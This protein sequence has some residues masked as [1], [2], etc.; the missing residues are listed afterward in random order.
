MAH[1]DKN[2]F[3]L[4]GRDGGPDRAP[5]GRVWTAEEQAEKLNGYLEISPEFWDQI[6]YGTHVRYFSKSEGFRPG[7]FVVKNPFDSKSKGGVEKRF[8][9]L[10]N[11]LNDKVRGYQQWVVA[12][13]DTAKF[14]V[15]PDAAT[16]VMMQSL[17]IAVKG[18]NDNVRK[19]AEH[20]RKLESRLVE[21]GEIARRT[22]DQCK[23]L[24]SL[25]AE[26]SRR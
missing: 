10:Q 17:E 12:Y 13:C 5:Q 25:V 18:L 15:K 11:G 3:D 19:V 4:E 23:K 21:M 14:F 20:S 6:R 2:P 7:G 8:M 22:A 24:E 16:L 1:A 9:K 26:T